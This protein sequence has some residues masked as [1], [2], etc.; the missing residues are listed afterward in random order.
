VTVVGFREIMTVLEED[1]MDC[2][3]IFMHEFFR[4]LPKKPLAV[5][6]KCRTDSVLIVLTIFCVE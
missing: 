3:P 6:S 4:K 5:M 2:K 1:Y